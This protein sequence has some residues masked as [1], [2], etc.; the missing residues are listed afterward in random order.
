MSVIE[1][2]HLFQGITNA[3]MTHG[4]GWHFIELGRYIER[5]SATAALLD[6]HYRDFSGDTRRPSTVGEYVEWVG[7]A[8]IVLRV[9]GVLPALHRGPAVRSHRRV[10]DPQRA[11]PAL[12]PLR[13]APHPGSLQAIAPADWPRPDARERLAGRL[14]ASLDYGQVD[15]IVERQPARLPRGDRP[16]GQPDQRG[17]PPAVH[18][19]PRRPGAVGLTHADLLRDPPRH[20]LQLRHARQREPDGG[21]HAA[22]QRGRAAVPALRAW[23][24]A[25]R[26]RPRRIATISGNS[27]HHFDTPS[28]HSELT[29]TARR[30]RAAGSAA[31]I[32][33]RR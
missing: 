2:V 7:L 21:A 32:A 25:P 18:R 10:P 31:G 9:R 23:R 22:A 19:L 6:V 29:L 1:G 16:A 28:R 11:V 4:E 14:L 27:V 20:A 15:E 17:R 3:T 5:A 12:G 30:A 33:R 26:A 13:G 24:S 8:A